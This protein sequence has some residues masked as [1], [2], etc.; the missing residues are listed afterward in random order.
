MSRIRWG[1]WLETLSFLALSLTCLVFAFWVDGV[2]G[3]LVYTIGAVGWG[4][5]LCRKLNAWWRS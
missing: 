2:A 1:V 4:I 3:K 5:P